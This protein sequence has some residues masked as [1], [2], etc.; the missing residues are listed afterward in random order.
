MGKKRPQQ[1]LQQSMGQ[2]VSKAALAQMGPAIERY[3]QAVVQN[4]GQQL[5]VQQ[6]STLET[7]FARV[8]VLEEIVI[9]KLGYTKETLAI[10]VAETEDDKEG[11]TL[12]EGALE[13]GDVVRLEISTKTKDQPEYQGS[14]RLKMYQTG[15]GQTIGTEL[16]DALIGM[17]AGETKEIEF[18]KDKGMVAKVIIDRVS[19]GPKEEPKAPAAEATTEQA[20]T[21]GQ[22]ADQT[23]GQ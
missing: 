23:Q 6:A 10:K 12:V 19:R 22:N 20:P 11:L 2:M 18:G 17:K 1:H 9:E 7:I 4:L 21:E 13:K 14:S 16:E 8:V 3:V 15:T 5:S